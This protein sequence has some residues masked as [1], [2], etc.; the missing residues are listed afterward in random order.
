MPSDW[1][2]TRYS[3]NQVAITNVWKLL[4]LTGCRL[5]FKSCRK[6]KKFLTD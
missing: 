2:K 5:I 1:P 4:L 6:A 3:D